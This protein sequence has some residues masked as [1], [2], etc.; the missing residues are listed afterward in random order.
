MCA[1]HAAF[2]ALLPARPL[3]SLGLLPRTVVSTSA[4]VPASCTCGTVPLPCPILLPSAA[5]ISP[6]GHVLEAV[7][8][9]GASR[10]LSPHDVP[11]LRLV[12]SRLASCQLFHCALPRMT[13]VM[14]PL[15]LDAP[16]R[17]AAFLPLCSVLHAWGSRLLAFCL[18]HP[19]PG[20][21]GPAHPWLSGPG[22]CLRWFLFH[23]F[24]L[25]FLPRMIQSRAVLL[26]PPAIPALCAAF[27]PPCF[28]LDV[29]ACGAG[30]RSLGWRSLSCLS[31]PSQ[32][33]L[34]EAS[35][36]YFLLYARTP[37]LALLLPHQNPA[38]PLWLTWQVRCHLLLSLPSRMIQYGACLPQVPLLRGIWAPFLLSPPRMFQSESA[39][40]LPLDIPVRGAVSLSLLSVPDAP[41]WC[42]GPAS[43]PDG[44]F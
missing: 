29:P 22:V 1:L 14:R 16:V 25:L 21:S 19:Y 28:A 34:S 30:P 23:Q 9:P 5:L 3:C 33:L 35:R 27:L 40:P 2:A 6:P 10:L 11:L 13:R 15:P 17:W 43:V 20:A 12:L 24:F 42:F 39:Y 26:R 37:R 8:L 36:L 7:V 4:F 41:A 44:P 38:R 18:T 32:T 31:V